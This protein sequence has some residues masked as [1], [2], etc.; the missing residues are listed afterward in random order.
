MA[1]AKVLLIWITSLRCPY[2]ISDVLIKSYMFL[3]NS[4]AIVKEFMF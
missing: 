3:M 1:T 2:S 4:F